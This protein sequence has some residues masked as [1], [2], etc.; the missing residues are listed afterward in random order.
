MTREAT[1][2]TA[3]KDMKPGARNSFWNSRIWPTVCSL[4]PTK[5]GDVRMWSDKPGVYYAH[6]LGQL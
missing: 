1:I 6:R 3:V 2:S 4:G 5:E